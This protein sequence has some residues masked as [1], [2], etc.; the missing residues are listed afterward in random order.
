MTTNW[1]TIIVIIV[2]VIV[3]EQQQYTSIGRVIING[4]DGNY[5][6]LMTYPH[7][8]KFYRPSAIR[9]SVVIS[10]SV[11]PCRRQCKFMNRQLGVFVDSIVEPAAAYYIHP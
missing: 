9:R 7:R 3:I 10:G 1:S 11:C 8:G 2:I 5:A 4:S 6:L